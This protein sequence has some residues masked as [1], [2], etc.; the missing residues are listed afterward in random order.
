MVIWIPVILHSFLGLTTPLKCSP[1]KN[2][3]IH[4]LR[5]DNDFQFCQQIFVVYQKVLGK[6]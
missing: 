2:L 5:K 3:N 4:I 6:G 1:F